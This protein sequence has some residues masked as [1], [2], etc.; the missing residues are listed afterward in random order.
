MFTFNILDISWGRFIAKWWHQASGPERIAAVTACGICAYYTGK[1]LG[2]LFQHS[3]DKLLDVLTPVYG[4]Y[5]LS[6]EA[7][8]P[9]CIKLFLKIRTL[10]EF[11]QWLAKVEDSTF[12]KEVCSAMEEASDKF[13]EFDNVRVS[14]TPEHFHLMVSSLAGT[15]INSKNFKEHEDGLTEKVYHVRFIVF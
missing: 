4:Q 12:H 2:E 1:G 3:K 6:I 5:H 11:Q 10:E 15:E 14:F 7:L 8:K 13:E 9:N